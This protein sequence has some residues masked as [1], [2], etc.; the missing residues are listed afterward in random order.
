MYTN[1]LQTLKLICKTEYIRP[2][3]QLIH[4]PKSVS[5][6]YVNSAEAFNSS[7][8]VEDG[9]VVFSS[10]EEQV[11]WIGT[12]SMYS[13]DL[14]CD[15][16]LQTT[17]GDGSEKV[18][19]PKKREA[20]NNQ[21]YIEFEIND[22]PVLV[23][24]KC[25]AEFRMSRIRICASLLEDITKAIQQAGQLWK[26]IDEQKLELS[27]VITDETF[28][29]QQVLNETKEEVSRYQTLVEEL[30]ESHDIS[31]N[32]LNL[33][34]DYLKTARADLDDA[35][36]SVK[37][38]TQQEEE[39]KEN[40]AK[41]QGTITTLDENKQAVERTLE[42][43]KGEL[44]KY[45]KDILRY[46]E[47]FSSYKDEL[48][49]Q[50]NKYYMFLVFLLVTAT[51]VSFKI[52]NHALSTVGNLQFN[53]DLWTL[54]VS[55]LPIITINLFILGTL[56]SLVYYTLKLI[57]ENAKSVATTKQVTCLVKECVE[58]QSSDL[59]VTDKEKLKQRVESKMSLIRDLNRKEEKTPTKD[60]KPVDESKLIDKLIEQLKLAK[61]S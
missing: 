24:I 30:T 60:S 4:R 22:I 29:Q 26:Q 58:A 11:H 44:V 6:G 48:T 57:T 5:N 49:K 59:N 43:L 46:S 37:E 52:Y 34:R 13:E 47:D 35:N 12:I 54:A 40:I 18:I 14:D 61:K 23:M 41:L 53:F 20:K 36:N 2:N 28:K 38:I 25:Q 16:K 56:S 9:S 10:Q 55:R 7:F 15:L 1:L 21:V 31:Q 42:D 17:L 32:Q 19:H 3:E 51:L 50:N 33:T 8:Y 45:E 39:T 27:E